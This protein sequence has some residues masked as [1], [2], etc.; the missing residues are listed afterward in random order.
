MN[1]ARALKVVLV[2]VGLLFA[3]GTLPMVIVLGAEQYHVRPALPVW[4]EQDRMELPPSFRFFA[5]R[6]RR[7]SSSG[8]FE[9]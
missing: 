4:S 1:R 5:E 2:L 9:N 3:A 7:W 8:I 6:N